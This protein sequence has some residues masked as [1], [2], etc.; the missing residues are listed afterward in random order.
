MEQQGQIF[1]LLPKVMESIGAVGKGRK[2]QMPG[3]SYAFRGIDDLYNAVQPSLIKHGITIVPVGMEI[4]R[5]DIIERQGKGPLLYTVV[6]ATYRFVA[7]DGSFVEA[8]TIGEAMDT[9]DK[10]CNKAMSAAMKY[11]MFQVLCIPTEEPKDTE[12]ETHELPPKQNA[13]AAA[14]KPAPY[15]PAPASKVGANPPVGASDLTPAIKALMR[16]WA[17]ATGGNASDKPAFVAFAKLQ[18]HEDE[19]GVDLAE[20]KNWDTDLLAIVGEAIKEKQVA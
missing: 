20:A 4:S 10:G 12:E 11:A 9:G 15:R 5:R 2:A 14:S 13:H 3:G 7:S 17:T 8:K 16:Q 18:L 6:S 1:G 19:Q